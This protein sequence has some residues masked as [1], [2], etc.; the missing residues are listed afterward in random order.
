MNC[1]VCRSEAVAPW[2]EVAGYVHYRC[3]RCQHLYVYPRPSPDEVEKHYRDAHF[4]D[5]AESEEPRLAEDAR[6]RVRMLSTLAERYGLE[7]C[8]LDVGCAS[9]IFLQ[10]A[11]EADWNVEGI[12]LSPAL[13][14]RARGRG[15]TVR[16]G[17]LVRA[18]GRVAFPVVTA[19]EVIEH[20]VDPGG[21]LDKLS[22][23]VRVG[24]L[25]A[26]STPLSTGLPARLLRSRFPMLCPPEHLSLFS[27]RSLQMLAGRYGLEPVRFR[28]FSNLKRR[29]LERGV[30]RYLLGRVPVPEWIWR[31]MSSVAAVAMLPL[32]AA[33]DAAGLGSEMEVVF[34]RSA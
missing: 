29:N 27:R 5:K 11:R 24:G 14:D 9:G 25:L 1:E 19:W 34:R 22:S 21:F 7:K 8:L 30:F 23:Y 4:Y 26:I 17:W 32:S 2:T 20:A 15:L 18:Q 12:E 33:M 3:G 13:A 6:S 31:G 16:T 28:S 10:Q